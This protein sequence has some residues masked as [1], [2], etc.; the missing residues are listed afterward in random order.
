MCSGFF[1][2][3]TNQIAAIV[4]VILYPARLIAFEL[5]C[6]VEKTRIKKAEGPKDDDDFDEDEDETM[7][8]GYPIGERGRCIGTE[9]CPVTCEARSHLKSSLEKHRPHPPS[10]KRSTQQRF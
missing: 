2:S 3:S 5:C 1:L 10:S 8:E 7:I 6:A 9:S 4:W